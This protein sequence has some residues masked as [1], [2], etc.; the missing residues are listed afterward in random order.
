[1][2]GM[3]LAFVTFWIIMIIFSDMICIGLSDESVRTLLHIIDRN[4]EMFRDELK[5]LDE[6]LKELEAKDDLTFRKDNV[7]VEE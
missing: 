3:T 4:V 6:D 5:W 7:N 2:R 1:M